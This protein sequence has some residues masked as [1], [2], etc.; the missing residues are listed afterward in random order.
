MEGP[1]I[2]LA[3][4]EEKIDVLVSEVG[5]LR[6]DVKNFS[7]RITKLEE[8]TR[9]A[10]PQV[11]KLRERVAHLEKETASLKIDLEQMRQ[12]YASQQQTRSSRTWEVFM[13]IATPIIGGIVGWLLATFQSGLGG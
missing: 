2:R 10:V 4:V 3:R 5:G 6:G 8:G 12:D 9:E 1:D 11:W 13:K 7:A